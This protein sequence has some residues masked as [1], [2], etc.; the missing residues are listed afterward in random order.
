MCK[1]SDRVP[2]HIPAKKKKNNVIFKYTAPAQS[3]RARIFDMH[4]GPNLTGLIGGQIGCMAFA[5]ALRVQ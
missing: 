1:E 5:I 2:T 4:I 3:P